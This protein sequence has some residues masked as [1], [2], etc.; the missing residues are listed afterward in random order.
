MQALKKAERAKQ[1]SGQDSELDKPSEAFDDILALAPQEPAAASVPA[2]APTPAPA[3]SFSLDSLS[4]SPIDDMPAPSP[5]P[6]PAAAPAGLAPLELS[7]ESLP[8]IPAASVA[9]EAIH[10]PVPPQARHVEAPPEAPAPAPA[11]ASARVK[12]EAKAEMQAADAAAR[13]DAAADK[14]AARAGGAAARA[15][16]AAAASA[17][18]ADKP[19]MDPAKLRIA[20]LGGIVVLIVLG[21]GY[22]FWQATSGPGSGGR[23]PMV[24][25]PPPNATG[26]TPALVV[27]PG[28]AAVKSEA[29]PS[30]APPEPPPLS[31]QEKQ[32]RERQQERD[33]LYA[34][35]MSQIQTQLQ[36]QQPPPAPPET[37]PAVAAPEN[38][39]IKVA[40]STVPAQVPPA[41]TSAYGALG[42]GDLAGAQ[43]QYDAMLQQD[44]NNR[45]ALLGVAAVA[46]RQRQDERAAAAYG[47]MLELDPTDADALA[48]LAGLRQGDPNQSELRLK[49]ALKRN[50][51][52]GPLLFALGNL[53]ARQSRWSEAQQTYFRAYSAVPTNA[54][55][56]FNLAI[57]LDR[58]NQPKL[59][60]TYYQRALALAQDQQAG[61]DRAALRKRLQE[62]GAPAQ[63]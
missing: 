35:L 11:S 38:S 58:L 32:R 50:P 29:A 4:L 53:Y 31:S 8:P 45:D 25:M 19:G 48:G 41:L 52:S 21:Y 51:D 49:N 43:Q 12:A 18:L 57:G 10:D 46:Q 24:P 14:A 6:A 20:V 26:A 27:V 56:A 16:A 55:Y 42:H 59:A 9:A 5:A 61:F 7:A 47:R 13:V 36:Q 28:A 3:P 33:Q 1:N 34:Q 22:Y 44:P 54:D 37:L 17:P 2:P 39:D 60:L 63:P 23:L 30:D 62:L 15:R 40:R